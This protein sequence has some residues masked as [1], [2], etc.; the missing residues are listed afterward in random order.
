MILEVD[1]A[2]YTATIQQEFV[3]ALN[4]AGLKSNG[5]LENSLQVIQEDSPDGPVL[6]ISFN[7]YGIFLD[8]GVR[9]AKSAAK[10]PQSPFGYKRSNKGIFNVPQSSLGLPAKARG[11][12]YWYGIKPYPWVQKF[13]DG[14]LA[15]LGP[16]VGED[17]FKSITKAPLFTSGDVQVKASI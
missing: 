3:N 12:I 13:M 8:Q 14:V 4:A 11:A 6:I 15:A 1:L 16:E 17:L 5:G 7:Q 2:K 10:A 9:G